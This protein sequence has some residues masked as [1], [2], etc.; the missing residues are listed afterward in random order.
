[1]DIRVRR[2][3]RGRLSRFI[4]TQA[5][6][7]QREPGREHVCVVAPS[8]VDRECIESELKS[9]DPSPGHS[10]LA[11]SKPEEQIFRIVTH[12]SNASF[13]RRI[14]FLLGIL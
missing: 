6:E 12:S 14:F 7:V 2:G 10:Q 4:S 8:R 11:G 13:S 9:F 3:G 1:M 5:V